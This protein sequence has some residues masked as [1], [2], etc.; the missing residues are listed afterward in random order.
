VTFLNATGEI[1]QL[2]HARTYGVESALACSVLDA[3]L[4][5]RKG[6]YA[7]SPLTTGHRARSLMREHGVADT[8]TLRNRL[9]EAGYHDLLWNPNVAEALA[10]AE[11][12]RTELGYELVIT[13]APFVA[14][15]WSQ[16]EYLAFWERVIRSRVELVFFNEGWQYSSGCTFEYAVALDAGIPA[17]D[18]AGRPMVA[19]EARRLVDEALCD[20]EAEELASDLMRQSVELIRRVT[21]RAIEPA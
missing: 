11:R 17:F 1:D 8:S 18:A 19:S 5:G 4:N 20:L 21:G 12:I 14:P 13:P 7:S 15:D 16:Q 2:P 3:V 10:F 9:G 6:V